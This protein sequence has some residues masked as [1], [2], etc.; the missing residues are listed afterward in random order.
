MRLPA[1]VPLALVAPLVF[2]APGGKQKFLE[3]FRGDLA[4]GLADHL[5][6]MLATAEVEPALGNPGFVLDVEEHA[7]HVEDHRANA[8]R[9]QPGQK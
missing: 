7:A 9:W 4:A 5:G 6:E 2:A 3:F 1:S 8:H